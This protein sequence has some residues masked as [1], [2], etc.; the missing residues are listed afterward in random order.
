[1]WAWIAGWAKAKRAKQIRW[2]SRNERWKW[3]S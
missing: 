2:R 3:G 1:M